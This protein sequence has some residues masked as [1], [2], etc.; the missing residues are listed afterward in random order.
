MVLIVS[1]KLRSP[2][3]GDKR[4]ESEERREGKRVVFVV[5]LAG[6]AC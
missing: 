3:N 4:R 2:R 6:N 1:R 5:G